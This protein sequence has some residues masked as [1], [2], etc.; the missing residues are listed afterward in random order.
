[1]KSNKLTLQLLK[2]NSKDRE[3]LTV[4][5]DIPQKINIEKTHL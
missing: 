4:Y 3:L 2:T 5:I 1:M